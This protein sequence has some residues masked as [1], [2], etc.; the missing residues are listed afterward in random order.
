LEE[1]ENVLKHETEE[2]EKD[3]EVAKG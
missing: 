2:D 3:K 1:L